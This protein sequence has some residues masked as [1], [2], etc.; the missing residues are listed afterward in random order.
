MGDRGYDCLAQ[1]IADGLHYPT[2]VSEV[3]PSVTV[4]AAQR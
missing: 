3:M 2:A 4:T 1:L